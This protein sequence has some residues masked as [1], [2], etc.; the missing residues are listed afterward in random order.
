MSRLKLETDD[1]GVAPGVCGHDFCLACYETWVVEQQ[2]LTCPVC[3]AFLAEEV[4]GV[5]T[6]LRDMIQQ[7]F[8]DR[9][10]ERRREQ[11]A[12][13][14][15]RQQRLQRERQQ[16]RRL[17][18]QAAT[19]EPGSLAGSAAMTATPDRHAEATSTLENDWRH[20]LLHG[21]RPAAGEFPSSMGAPLSEGAASEA[22]AP[23]EAARQ[24]PVLGG[25][26]PVGASLAPAQPVAPQWDMGPPLETLAFTPGWCDAGTSRRRPGNK[27]GRWRSRR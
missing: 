22:Q 6:R 12:L 7:R 16:R 14:L 17:R 18:R 4:P 23:Q 13:Q 10:R 8:P 2:K 27:T 24:P 26:P 9:L 3:R 19:G 5:C 1:H 25:G 11:Q 20:L 15:S 21:R